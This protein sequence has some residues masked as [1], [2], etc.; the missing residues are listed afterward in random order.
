MKSE[1]IGIYKDINHDL[2][3]VVF[4]NRRYYYETITGTPDRYVSNQPPGRDLEYVGQQFTE[5]AQ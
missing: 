3:R 5:A 2:V 4:E 1:M